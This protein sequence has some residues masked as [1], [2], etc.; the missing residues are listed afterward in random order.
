MNSRGPNLNDSSQICIGSATE[1]VGTNGGPN[2]YFG[3]AGASLGYWRVV[4]NGTTRKIQV[5]ADV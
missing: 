4:I 2:T 1:Y 5:Y 3:A